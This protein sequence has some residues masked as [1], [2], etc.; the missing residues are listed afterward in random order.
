MDDD[1]PLE[2]RN[3]VTGP[4]GRLL[5]ELPKLRISI[6][7][8]EA[9]QR[10]AAQSDMSLSEYARTVLDV[11]CFGTDHIANLAADRVRQALRMGGKQ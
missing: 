9:L 2:S 5:A 3:G 4:F 10:R 11:H 8:I 7:T 6:E 1:L